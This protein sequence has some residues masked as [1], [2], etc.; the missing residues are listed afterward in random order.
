M[1]HVVD[2]GGRRAGA[3]GA[4]SWRR[5]RWRGVLQLRRDAGARRRVHGGVPGA[6][7]GDT[8]LQ[9]PVRAVERPRR[10]APDFG[11]RRRR[12]GWSGGE[13][14][15]RRRRPRQGGAGGHPGVQVQGVGVGGGARRRRGGVRGVPERHAGRRRGARAARVRPRLPRRLRRRLAPRP[16]HLPRLPRAPRRAASSAGETTLP[17][18]AGARRRRRRP[19]AGRPGEPSIAL[20]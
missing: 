10:R 2:G 20:S 14:E 19:A 15:G 5:R 8:L 17:E 1:A 4:A 3:G 13:E 11:R 18:G 6:V 7:R 16:R 9:L 12:R